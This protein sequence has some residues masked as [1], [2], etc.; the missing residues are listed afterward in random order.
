MAAKGQTTIEFND[1][2]FDEIMRSA[3]VESLTKDAATRA[4]SIARATAPVDTGSYRDQI[5]VIVRESRYR[6]VYRVV[7]NDPKTLLIESKTG[8]LAR[9][10]KA[11]KQ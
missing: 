3:G 7:G 5:R 2:F 8:N 10:L 11:A 4:A 6:R 1:A 9:A